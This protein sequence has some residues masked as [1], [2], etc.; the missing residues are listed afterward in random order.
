MAGVSPQRVETVLGIRYSEVLLSGVAEQDRNRKVWVVQPAQNRGAEVGRRSG[1]VEGESNS[2]EEASA[3]LPLSAGLGDQPTKLAC[4]FPHRKKESWILSD[5]S[6]NCG[7][8]SAECIKLSYLVVDLYC[9]PHGS[10]P[11]SIPYRREKINSGDSFCLL[12]S[13]SHGKTAAFLRLCL[14]PSN[15]Q[16]KQARS[17][18]ACVVGMFGSCPGSGCQCTRCMSCGV[19]RSMSPPQA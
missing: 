5:V 19:D 7:C 2:R 17:P 13:S 1:A 9:V 3:K 6:A 12:S 8:L 10:D 4:K 11:Y 14:H 18:R 16:P 15:W